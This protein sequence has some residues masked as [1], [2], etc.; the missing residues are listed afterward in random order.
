MSLIGP[1]KGRPQKNKILFEESNVFKFTS[2]VKTDLSR[3][4]H[5]IL[6]IL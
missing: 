5:A 6:I 2:L 3:W 1:R 4:M